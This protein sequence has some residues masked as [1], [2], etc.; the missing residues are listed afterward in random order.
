MEYTKENVRLSC[1]HI[2]ERAGISAR[3]VEALQETQSLPVLCRHAAEEA[4]KKELPQSSASRVV[5]LSCEIVRRALN[6]LDEHGEFQ[7]GAQL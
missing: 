1:V 4:F 6:N 3:S 7:F 5:K 2:L